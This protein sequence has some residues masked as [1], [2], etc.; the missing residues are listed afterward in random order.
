MK[1]V[2]PDK[3]TTAG[4]ITRASNGTYYDSTGLLKT[5]TTNE[6]RF[7]HEPFTKEY[8]G[9]LLEAAATNLFPYSEQFESWYS[10]NTT[11]SANSGTDPAGTSLADKIVATTTNGQHFFA[12][13]G[14]SYPVTAGNTY[15]ISIYVKAAGVDHVRIDWGGS[16]GVGNV[17]YNLST[18]TVGD[19]LSGTGITAS[20]E[21]L[22]NGWYR[23]VTSKTMSSSGTS[24]GYFVLCNAANSNANWAGN[25]TSG[26]FA[27]GAQFESGSKATSYIKTTSTSASR[28][29]DIVTGTGLLYTSATNAYAE[30]SSSTTYSLGQIVSYGILGTYKSLQNSNLNKIPS[31]ETAYWLRIA[32]TNKMACFDDKVS[33]ATTSATT[34]DFVVLGNSEDTISLLNLIGNS[35]SIAVSTNSTVN[36]TGTEQLAGS[37]SIDWYSYFYFDQD[38]ARTQAN[39][40]NIVGLANQYISVRINGTNVQIGNYVQGQIKQLGDTQYGASAGIIDYSK[41]ET[42]EFGETTLTVRNYSKRMNSQ[43]MISNSNINRV[44]RLLY[45]LRAT[46]AL[47]I[48]SDDLTYEEPLIV[49][50]FY[51]D[52][53][54]EISYPTSSIC[55]L[56]IEGLI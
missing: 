44:Q 19:I 43:L 32:P 18:G 17:Y 36:Y 55:N 30:W 27:Y 49:F 13:D 20:I 21:K 40:F 56:E 16:T 45:S 6:V 12:A 14:A 39:F 31:T 37:E 25:G 54:T 5:A 24:G 53:S 2:K 11:T 47:W 9:V 10:V 8:Q 48:G 26:I 51:K 3:V 38:T 34:L 33:T 50:G 28:A 1:V 15:T 22:P 46:P 29:A 42:D 52:F 7:T 41:K 35:V 4:S 23:L